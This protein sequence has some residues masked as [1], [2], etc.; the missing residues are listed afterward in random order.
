MQ[1]LHWTKCYRWL[2][3][4]LRRC[5]YLSQ[6]ID[7]E[8]YVVVIFVYLIVLFLCDDVGENKIDDAF[9]FDVS[10]RLELW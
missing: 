4:L 5:D 9:R 7:D 1:E 10:H 6:H 2:F 3:V 8:G